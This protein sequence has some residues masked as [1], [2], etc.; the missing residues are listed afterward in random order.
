MSAFVVSV[1][2]MQRV[3]VC[4]RA[5]DAELRRL[6]PDLLGM[7][8]FELN[9]R[10]VQARYGH[11]EEVPEFR[12]ESR[13]AAMSLVS[14]YKSLRC[15][16]YQCDETDAVMD[17]LLIVRLKAAQRTLASTLGHMPDGSFNNPTVKLAYDAAEW[18]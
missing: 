2:C 17:H 16:L 5:Y 7:T 6:D 8:L 13:S 10:A 11:F 4:A 18:G 9:R 15:F 12:F 14:I 1:A 3:V